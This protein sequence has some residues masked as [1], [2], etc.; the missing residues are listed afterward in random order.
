MKIRKLLMGLLSALCVVG[1][2]TTL[3]SCNV[4][5]TEK[6]SAT[7]VVS[8]GTETPSQTVSKG[9][10]LT[11]PADPTKEGYEFAGWYKDYTFQNPWNFEED[12]VTEHIMIYAKWVRPAQIFTIKQATDFLAT[13]DANFVSTDRYII[14]ATV[15]KVT[16]PSYGAM[17]I[18]DDTGSISVYGSW[19]ED[20]E[21]SY[22]D[23]EDKPYAGDTVKLSC[24]L[25]NFNGTPEIKNARILEVTHNEVE[26][27]EADYTE[28]TINSV[29]EA[30]AGTKVKT[31][32]VVA[33]IT[34]ANG[35]IPSGVYLIDDTNS[36]YV[37]DSQ[38]AARV[39]VGNKITI[40]GTKAY[41]I[42]DTETNNA[43]KFGYKGCNQIDSVYLKSNDE[44]KNEFNKEWITE[45][46]VKEMMDTPVTEDITTK[47]FKVNALVKKVPG[48]GFTNY[49]INDIDGKTGSYVYTQCNGGDF[50]WLDEFD[51]K[52]CTVYLTVMNA[53]SSASGCLYRF[54]PIAVKDENY[55]FDLT[56]AAEYAVKYHGVDQFEKLYYSDPKLEVVTSVDSTL[57]GFTGATLTYTSS[58][59]DVIYFEVENGKTYM[60]A[61]G[62]EGTVTITIKGTHNNVEFTSNVSVKIAKQ[63]EY[64]SVTVAEAISANVGE[65]VIVKG[66]VGPSLVNK[67][68]FY[69]IDETGLIA[70]TTDAETLGQVALGNEVILKGKRTAFK[71]ETS[72]TIA[73]QSCL[74]DCVLL[75]NSYG[76]HD[77]STATFDD[78]KTLAELYTYKVADDYTTKGYVITATV[79]VVE[80]AY[81]TSINIQSGDTKLNLYSA[82]A[83]QYNFLK[84]FAGQEVVL[85]LALCNWNDKTYYTGC[86]LAVRLP[87]GSKIVNQLN[88]TK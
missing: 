24:I 59:N 22:A 33:A 39:Q 15:E 3:T 29:R 40:L 12:V 28:M 77:Y 60:R 2:T 9:D 71:K 79:N 55:T 50:A 38:L 49:Y 82:S 4:T 68:G 23:L 10:K 13:Q 26:I 30:E 57:L 69:L 19:S 6:F 16:N 64:D 34:Y 31:T 27:N 7:F 87:D 81:Y 66:I 47:V 17:V 63:A 65:E 54:Y 44:G 73:G 20:G 21:L 78:S 43:Q 36:I 5:Q 67:S 85:E 76:T 32:G 1:T 42:L 37:Y 72:T 25:Q 83:N 80:T 45:S 8:G 58:N 74:L 84:Q 46:T 51:G 61:T 41:W 14:T 56:K 88:F 86:I 75:T 52:F 53:K 18:K 70:I 48:N 62:T 11:K 35:Y